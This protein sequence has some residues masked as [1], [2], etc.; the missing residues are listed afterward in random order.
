[1][2]GRTV[3]RPLS[4][5]GQRP[6]A[7]SLS[8][9]LAT[10]MMR[11]HLFHTITGLA[12]VVAVAGCDNGPVEVDHP[13]YLA[14][15]GAPG[16]AAL[17]RCVEASPPDVCAIDGLPR[18]VTAAGAN[19]NFITVQV[20]PPDN[21]GYYYFAR[22]PTETRGW[23]SNPELIVGPISPEEFEQERGRLGLPVPIVEW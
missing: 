20:G 15:F 5:Q 3:E 7:D 14:S 9:C 21:R 18:K 19:D 17:V 2:T 8:N 1:M 23:G 16:E 12:V 4:T 11:R 10:V 13:F 6:V 22:L